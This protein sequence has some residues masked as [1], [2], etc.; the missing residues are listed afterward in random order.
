MCAIWESPCISRRSLR[1]GPTVAASPTVR[2]LAREIGVDIV[3]VKGTGPG[4]RI[5]EGDIKVFAKQLIA[6]L[7]HEAATAKAAPKVVLPDFSKWGTVEKEQ[8]RSIRRKTAER[9]SLAWTTIPHVTQH[10]RADIT[11]LE[12]LREKFAKQAE[13]AGGKLTVTAIALKVI[14]AAMKKFPKFNASIDVD[15]E[16]I[17]YKKYVHIGI[18][19]DTEAGLARSRHPQR[20]PERTF[21]RSR[22]S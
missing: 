12:K 17:I 13:A 6:R 1:D 8:M 20:R 22:R 7:Q 19:V 4:G 14:A 21:T 5:S 9:L 2:R 11:E 10:D 18:A 16:E 15:R 3:Q